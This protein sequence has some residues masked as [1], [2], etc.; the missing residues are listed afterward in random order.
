MLATQ[1]IDQMVEEIKLFIRYSVPE[2]EIGG[3][4]ALVDR[5]RGHRRILALLS[6][7]YRVLP[8]DR[9]EAAIRI[10]QLVQRQGVY[11]MVLSTT[12]TAHL[13]AVSVDEVIWLGEYT[14]RPGPEFLQFWEITGQEEILKNFV[15]VVDLKDYPDGTQT[16]TKE[17]P[18]CGVEPGEY[19]ILGCSVEVCP[20]CE[21]QLNKCNCRFEQLEADSIDTEEEVERFADLLAAKGRIPFQVSQAPYYPGT[22]EGLDRQ[23][24]K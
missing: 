4:I 23:R 19:H 5:Y 16:K 13:Y 18:V 9:E 22:S 8:D 24:K 20:W 17:C 10:S 14:G 21:G 7:Y 12:S 6:E 1:H 11:L 3:A 15:P 2:S